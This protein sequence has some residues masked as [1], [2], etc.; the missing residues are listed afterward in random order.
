MVNFRNARDRPRN[1]R[2][3]VPRTSRE[4]PPTPLEALD[5]GDIEQPLAHGYRIVDRPL[6]LG[7]P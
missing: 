2:N 1:S 7:Q 6:E 4:N 3:D 5:I